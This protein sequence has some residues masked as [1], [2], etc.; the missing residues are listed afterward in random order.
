MLR[1]LIILLALLGL[2]AGPITAQA[3]AAGSQPTSALSGDFFGNAVQEGS[4]LS[5]ASTGS[6]VRLTNITV[7]SVSRACSRGFGAACNRVRATATMYV[8]TDR[9]PISVSVDYSSSTEWTVTISASP[10]ASGYTPRA[11]SPINLSTL[12]GAIKKSTWILSVSLSASGTYG[13]VPVSG[14]ATLSSTGIQLTATVTDIPLPGGSSAGTLQITANSGTSTVQ[15]S[16]LVGGKAPAVNVSLSWT[17]RNNWTAGITRDSAEGTAAD[18]TAVTMDGLSGSITMANGVAS[19]SLQLSGTVGG[20][21]FTANLSGSR[22]GGFEGTA[23]V[24]SLTLAGG[25]TIT[26]AQIT[27]STNS[28][29]ASIA[30]TLTTTSAKVAVSATY[31]DSSNWSVS[32]AANSAPSGYV[33][34]IATSLDINDLSGTITD[35]GGRIT[36]ALTVSGVTVG[37]ATFDMTATIDASGVEASALVSNMVIGGFTLESASISISTVQEYADITAALTTS[38]GNFDVDINAAALS[39]GGYHIDMTADGADLSVGSSEFYMQ[40]FGF[41]WS[42]DVP[43]SGCTAVDVAVNGSVVMKNTTY[44]LNN[45][46]VA[47][48]CSTLTKF[49]FSVTV[50]HTSTWDNQVKRVTLTVNWLT[51][52]GSYTPTFG[53]DNQFS[54]STYS[55]YD[56][57]FGTVDLSS[58]R[59]FSRSGM[60]RT[61]TLGLGFSVAVYQEL[62]SVTTGYQKWGSVSIPI[63][64]PAPGPW[65]VAIG[66]MG[67]FDADRVSGDIACTFQAAP[68]TDFTCGGDIRINPSF[69]GVWHY[70]WTGI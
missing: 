45:A 28:S 67:Y 56:G 64:E 65:A 50:V 16:I 46:E 47:F 52:G 12:S 61:V 7:S 57:F 33:T 32:I 58:T 53:P 25:Y 20:S 54:G 70:D 19:A 42:A 31:T 8:G 44:T 13:G 15:A 17:D 14:S 27:V 69:A 66:A 38:A 1:R 35:A 24:D 26:D 22:N 49:V 9:T 3:V 39:G 68:A 59:G 23:S 10:T 4:T 18:G 30:G 43:A 62:S 37:D 51:G 2:V 41:S 60:N 29:T 55:Y 11:G 63:T 34:P 48:S 21:A 40:S 5:S 36:T 6:E